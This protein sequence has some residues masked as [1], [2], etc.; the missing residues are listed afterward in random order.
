M[1]SDMVMTVTVLAIYF[2]LSFVK[3]P[4]AN[5]EFYNPCG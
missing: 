5:I 1:L 3:D 4:A 2:F